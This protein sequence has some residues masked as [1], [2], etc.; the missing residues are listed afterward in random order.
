MTQ[1]SNRRI[2][3][4]AVPLSE[5][6]NSF[7]ADADRAALTQTPNFLA[8]L[9]EDAKTTD[10]L[11][12]FAS[13]GLV[14]V[15]SQQRRQEIRKKMQDELL[16]A[17]FASDLV[18][19]GYRE[20]PSISAAPAHIDPDFFED[21]QIDLKEDAAEAFGKRYNRIR[22]YDPA[23]LLPDAKPKIGRPGA[24]NRIFAAIRDLT[25]S[26]PDF[27]SL[28]RKKACDEIRNH[29]GEKN[30]RGSGLSDQNIEKYI[31]KICGG[32]RIG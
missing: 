9:T 2:W 4:N 5:A 18:A 29:I 30:I 20:K 24:A 22:I 12:D 17:L 27:C 8:K 10:T 11:M 6:W 25:N 14:A 28:P 32:R 21:P 7:A 23:T 3:E 1:K 31:I 15:T 13:A 26:N 16:D 19:L